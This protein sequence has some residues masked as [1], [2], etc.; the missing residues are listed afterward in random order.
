VSVFRIPVVKTPIKIIHFTKKKNNV[1]NTPNRIFAYTIRS[2]LN[3]C[4][5]LFYRKSNGKQKFVLILQVIIGFTFCSRILILLSDHILL[6]IEKILSTGDDVRGVGQYTGWAEWMLNRDFLVDWPGRRDKAFKPGLSRLK[7]DVWY[8]YI[9][10]K[11]LNII[12]FMCLWCYTH[13]R[14]KDFFQGGGSKGFSPN[15]FRGGANSGEVCFYPSKLKKQPFLL[16]IS[17]SRVGQGPSLP[18][19]RRPWLHNDGSHRKKSA[20][21]PYVAFMMKQKPQFSWATSKSR[22][23]KMLRERFD[24]VY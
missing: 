21:P 24:A 15:F 18:P 16:I 10:C 23:H 1:Q 6:I 22:R 13:G 17:K 7:R 3:L 9:L 19:F 8:A 12:T 5:I 11:W 20:F 4:S 14:R 2:S